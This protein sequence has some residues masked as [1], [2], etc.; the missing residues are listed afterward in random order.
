MK[1]LTVI[2]VNNKKYSS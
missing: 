2:T 1:L